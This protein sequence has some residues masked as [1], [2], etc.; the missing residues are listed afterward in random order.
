MMTDLPMHPESH[1]LHPRRA[2]GHLVNLHVDPSESLDG[3]L[4]HICAP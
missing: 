1:R 2:G 3:H 4:W